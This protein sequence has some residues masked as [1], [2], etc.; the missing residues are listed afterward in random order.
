MQGTARLGCVRH[1]LYPWGALLSFLS[2]NFFSVSILVVVFFQED[3]ACVVGGMA[4]GGERSGDWRQA[5]QRLQLQLARKGGGRAT[6]VAWTDL[7]NKRRMGES[8]P[9]TL[10]IETRR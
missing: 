2:N 9:G 7:A 6:D 8:P 1:G 10:P 5:A 3:E 4:G